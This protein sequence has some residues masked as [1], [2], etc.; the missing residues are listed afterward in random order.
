MTTAT[1]IQRMGLCLQPLDVLFFRDGRPFG[2][3]TRASSGHPMPQTLTGALRTALLG[4]LGFSFAELAARLRRNRDDR[5][6]ESIEEALKKCGAPEWIVDA[7]IRGPFLARLG[8]NQD[9]VDVLVPVPAVLHQA[10]DGGELERLKPL[11][12]G[13]LPGWRGEL[14]PLWLR[15]KEPTEPATG[16]LTNAGL[17]RFLKGG[18]P[19]PGQLL[20]DGALFGLDHRTGIE[21][22]GDQLTAKDGGIYGASF[23]ALRPGYVPPDSRDEGEKPFAVGLYAELVYPQG[24]PPTCQALDG[25]TLP[26]GGEGRRVAVRCQDPWT[27]PEGQPKN[28][29]EKPLLVL[30]TPGLFA[31]PGRP[32]VLKD[33]LAAAAVPAAVAVSGWDLARGGPKPNRFAAAAGSVYFLDSLPD[34]LP[35]A[36]SDRDEDRAQG[37][38][39][40]VK[41]VW[42]DE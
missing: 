13:A 18:V 23:L 9:I 27:W 20:K 2:A 41:G 14:R 37:W 35:D 33:C 8:D 26:L 25:S 19:E 4:Q 22:T 10:K 32:E 16:Y 1:K 34:N 36:L 29:K 15:H 38:G 5:R 12:A 3:A 24:L 6:E 31:A 7:R 42:T 39:C 28:P 40:Y 30:T 21:I 17:Q 11:K